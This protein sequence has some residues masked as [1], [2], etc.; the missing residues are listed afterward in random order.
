M[1]EETHL[2]TESP[3]KDQW[4]RLAKAGTYVGLLAVLA[5]AGSLVKRAP[6][7]SLPTSVEQHEKNRR[8]VPVEQLPGFGEGVSQARHEKLSQ[9]AAKVFYRQKGG[10]GLWIPVC[11]ANKIENNSSKLDR[12]K[13]S[14]STAG[15]CFHVITGAKW[16]IMTAGRGKFANVHAPA[17]DLLGPKVKYEYG[18]T[19]AKDAATPTDSDIL[20][21]NH[22]VVSLKEKD[23]AMITADLSALPPDSKLANEF[24]KM[25]ALPAGS[26]IS[27][28]PGAAVN[29][30][31]ATVAN[32]EQPASHTGTLLGKINI[33]KKLGDGHG[34]SSDEVGFKPV[35]AVAFK[36][37]KAENYPAA[38]GGSGAAA[39][40]ASGQILYGITEGIHLNF[41]THS[42][43]PN[44]LEVERQTGV[45][46][47]PKND[48]TIVFFEDAQPQ[49]FDE[50]SQAVGH[51]IP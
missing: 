1:T 29:V 40:T 22:A 33:K 7:E 11:M 21:I 15:H 48:D 10:N 20:P 49:D 41:S 2:K 37:G 47:D 28:K 4:E 30:I 36:S 8:P 23:L 9:S 14:F 45:K 25:P 24:R 17:V 39:A 50:L 44:W 34:I 32:L 12:N 5:S 38:K 6:A 3:P 51:Y 27:T 19:T 42:K 18:V 16:G 26:Q 46:L 13:V 35:Y 31:S 43:P